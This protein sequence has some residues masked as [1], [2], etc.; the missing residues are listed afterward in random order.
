MSP[1]GELARRARVFSAIRATV[2]EPPDFEIDVRP[3]IAG[4]HIPRRL[5]YSAVLA[6]VDAG[7]LEYA[8]AGPR[9]RVTALGRAHGEKLPRHIPIL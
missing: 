7:L 6:L 5:V 4:L 1:E 2:A 8:G 9:V 3:L